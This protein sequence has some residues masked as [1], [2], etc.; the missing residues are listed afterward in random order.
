MGYVG[1]ELCISIFF[2]LLVVVL[3]PVFE[4]CIQFLRFSFLIVFF[5]FFLFW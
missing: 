5:F 2:F 4:D 1:K 3:G